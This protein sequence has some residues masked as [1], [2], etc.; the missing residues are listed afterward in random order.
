MAFSVIL[1]LLLATVKQ[2]LYL[3]W[4][5]LLLPKLGDLGEALTLPW[6]TELFLVFRIFP[7]TL[8]QPT[9]SLCTCVLVNNV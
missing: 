3:W 7:F 4:S 2:S 5:F 9:A 8:P 1:P 6:D